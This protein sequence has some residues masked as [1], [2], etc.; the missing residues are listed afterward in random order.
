MNIFTSAKALIGVASAAAVTVGIAVAVLLFSSTGSASE[1]A[2][3]AEVNGDPVTA[4]QFN[5][6][7]GLQRAAVIDY[8]KRT[9]GADI[10]RQFWD[11]DFGGEVPAELAKERALKQAVKLKIQLQ[12]VKSHGIVR[13]TSYDDL[14]SEMEE[15]NARRSAALQAGRPVY[16]PVR[17]DENTFMD[18]Y[19]GKVLIE[20]K[21]KLSGK[22]LAAT[23]EQL[24]QHYESIKDGL[25][26]LEDDVRYDMIT[27]SYLEDGVRVDSGKKEAAKVLMDAAKL[28]LEQGESANEAVQGLQDADMASDV[29]WTEERLTNETARMVSKSQPVLYDALAELTESGRVSPVIDDRAAGRYVLARLIEREPNGYRSFEE[30]KANV[31]SHYIDAKFEEYADQLIRDA[32][33]KLVEDNYNNVKIGER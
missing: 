20:L 17:F 1:S 28:R 19:I 29:Q 26:R 2:P 30:Q 7:L 5:R 12:L 14:L 9:H 32:D 24:L 3:I 8:F 16:G 21:A 13:G 33:V 31:R 4:A 11:T 23:E 25:F 10:D 27:A 18:F 22:E 15:E 6:L